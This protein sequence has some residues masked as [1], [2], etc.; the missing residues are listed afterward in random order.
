MW[1][2]TTSSWIVNDLWKGAITQTLEFLCLEKWALNR[3][4]SY[5]LISLLSNQHEIIKYII[6]IIKATG[7]VI[8][9]VLKNITDSINLSLKFC[10]QLYLIHEIGHTIIED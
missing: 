9:T 6:K 2:F 1:E 4:L 3:G 8:F 5:K 7:N 10:G